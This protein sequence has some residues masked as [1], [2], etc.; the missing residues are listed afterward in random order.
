MLIKHRCR[1]SV[2]NDQQSKWAVAK[3]WNDGEASQFSLEKNRL[4]ELH[5]HVIPKVK[6]VKNKCAD[7]AQQPDVEAMI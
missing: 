5:A 1:K 4:A 3:L 2:H 7:A 6:K